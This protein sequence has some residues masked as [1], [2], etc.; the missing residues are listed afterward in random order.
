MLIADVDLFQ[1]SLAHLLENHSA[2]CL[3]EL[4]QRKTMLSRR[5][6]K[7]KQKKKLVENYGYDFA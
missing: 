5:T 3:N 6:D 4:Q 2:V 1:S 7:R